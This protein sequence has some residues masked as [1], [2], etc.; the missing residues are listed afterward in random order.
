MNVVPAPTGLRL[1]FLLEPA[2][3]VGMVNFRG[4]T[5]TISYTRLLQV[6]D[7]PDEDPFD[8]AR[9]PVAEQSL[10]EFLQ[11]NGY[12]QASVQT[13]S[14][15]DDAHEL[16]NVTFSVDLGKQARIGSVTFEGLESREDA[17]LLHSVRSL[18]AR[19]T[20]GLLKRGKPYSP[21]RITAATTQIRRTLSSQRRLANKVQELP[22]QYHSDSNR[23]DVS[24]KVELGPVV[25]VR[26]TGARLTLLPLMSGRE[27]KK[28]IPI[29]SEGAIDRDLVEEGQRNLIDYF[30]KK[31]YFDVQVKIN[32]QRQPDQILLVYEIDKGKK[33]TV[34]GI[35]FQGN[36]EITD[37]DLL[38]Q[39]VVK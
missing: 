33:H 12:F 8:K 20:G 27:T 3:Y 15:I 16:V 35:L 30:Q 23:V 2:F 22:P 7:L 38:A 24:F 6:V 28:L 32:F 31:G 26:T 9:L 11:R 13:T 5:K 17:R 25:D 14:E 34:D 4:L 21:E 10:R 36:H 19:F 1:N 29:Y 37:K 18:R 39:V